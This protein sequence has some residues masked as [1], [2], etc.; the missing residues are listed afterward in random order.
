VNGRYLGV[1]EERRA[2]WPAALRR[3]TSP[4]ESAKIHRLPAL[5]PSQGEK[6]IKHRTD[7]THGEFDQGPGWS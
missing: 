4:P 1:Q 6:E 2:A 5:R 3:I 7:P